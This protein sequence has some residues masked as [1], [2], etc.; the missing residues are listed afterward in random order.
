MVCYLCAGPCRS[1]FACALQSRKFNL[2][3]GLFPW[4]IGFPLLALAIGQFAREVR[5]KAGGRP[6]GRAVEDEEPEVP[7]DVANR[8]TAGMFG[9]IISYFIAI[10]LLGF[11]I[12]GS[13]CSFIQL[14]FAS[15]EKWLITI[16]M[17]AGLWAFVYLL[18]QQALHVPFPDGHLFELLGW[19]E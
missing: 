14:K 6:L 2:R 3:A 13:L 19:V 16:L 1:S 11:P 18:F 5:G 4:A 8:R 10:W 17:T 12:G 9:W 15:K 7:P